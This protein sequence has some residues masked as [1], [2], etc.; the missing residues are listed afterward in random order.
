MTTP[1][2]FNWMVGA[3]SL[4]LRQSSCVVVASYVELIDPPRVESDVLRP[5]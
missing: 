2:P 3:M 5:S 1:L 4:P